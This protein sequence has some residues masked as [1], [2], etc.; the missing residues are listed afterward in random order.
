MKGAL[1]SA[2]FI[3]A[4]LTLII[5]AGQSFAQ[6]PDTV[7]LYA[8]PPSSGSGGPTI[9]QF[10]MADTLSGGFRAHPNRVYLLQQTS[11]VDT[12]YYYSDPIALKGN[13]TILG[14]LN[15]VT[16][17]PPIIQPW[18]R[19]DNTAPSNFMAVNDTGTVIL[20]D[21]YISGQ[22]Y[23]SVQATGTL[24]NVNSADVTISLDHVV[25]DNSNGNVAT[26]NGTAMDGKFIANNVE[27]RNVSNQFWRSG[28]L[29]W[30]NSP[31][32]MDSVI[33]Q[34]CTFF[35]QG[36]CIY[37]GPW[38]YRYLL[39]NHNT[40]FFTSDAPLLSTH[41]INATITNNIFYGADAHG[42]DSAS[43]V[44]S[45]GPG[46]D[47]HLP[48]SII[49]L[50]SL[51]GYAS[52]YGITESQRN[53]AVKNNV[54]C[55]PQKLYSYWNTINDTAKGWYIE[56]PKWMNALTDTMFSDHTDWPG[57]VEANNDSVDPGFDA[58][59]VSSSSDS[60]TE[61]EM[62][63]GWRTSYGPWKDA[64][65]FRWWQLWTNPYPFHVFDNVPDSW[66]SWSDGYPVPENLKYSNVALQ[67]SGTDGMPLGDLNWFTNITGI[68]ELSNVV[69]VKFELS[70][71]Y[72]N[73]FNPTT[74][75]NYA[76]PKSGFTS[77]K[78]YNILGQ[79]VAT[80][81]QGFQK[82][83]SYKIDFNASNLASG[84][85]LYRL[86]VGDFNLT[87]KMILMK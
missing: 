1:I 62:L 31:A 4:M 26:F 45:P 83:G 37:G 54:Y 61:F 20:R 29:F 14:K 76:M 8:N 81:Y 12:P 65:S 24:I 87:K 43:I 74:T 27:M 19:L 69:P 5:P 11:S 39:L 70:Q 41:Q 85:Y 16:G 63:V 78:V 6:V 7:R 53:I 44:G 68:K 51:K 64:G 77:L 36:R 32:V 50:D 40:V 86:Q 66:K 84:I 80:L 10:I 57:L 18:I 34:N 56:I 25:V 71:N 3:I 48:Y 17:K 35:L 82:A 59:L 58:Q 33:I 2:M 15:P 47:A 72:P 60:L 67:T 22:R 55:W 9:E 13:V 79:E 30:A 73:P 52:A 38:P 28:V 21:L 49:M 42:I 75:I 46:N 23:D